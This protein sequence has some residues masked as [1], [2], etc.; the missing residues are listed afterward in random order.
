MMMMM[1]SPDLGLV[2][3][4]PLYFATRRHHAVKRCSLTPDSRVGGVRAGAGGRV[5][6]WMGRS[7]VGNS[8]KHSYGDKAAEAAAER[9]F[10]VNGVGGAQSILNPHGT[11]PP[12]PAD[13]I[14]AT[15]GRLTVKIAYNMYSPCSRFA[16]RIIRTH[17]YI[18]T[19]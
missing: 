14:A 10:G 4:F 6:G 19:M 8:D 12:N 9:G 2:Q 15:A 5:N 16:C 17:F 1:I 13:T 3:P 18:S 11:R 7:A